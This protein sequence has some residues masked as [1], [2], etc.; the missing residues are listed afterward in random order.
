MLSEIRQSQEEKYGM[1]PLI[2]NILNSQTHRGIVE[3]WLPAAG[4]R[5]KWGVAV[6]QRRS[7]RYVRGI[8]SRGQLYDLSMVSLYPNLKFH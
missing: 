2:L 4:R 8:S 7:P 5:R 6:Q 1:I 3:W